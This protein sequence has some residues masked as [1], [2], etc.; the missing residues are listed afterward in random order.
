[1]KRESAKAA[2][3]GRKE[4]NHLNDCRTFRIGGERGELATRG[5]KR[6]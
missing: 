6:Q 2:P 5:E 4:N 3:A 1:M